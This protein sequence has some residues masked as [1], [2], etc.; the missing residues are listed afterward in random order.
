MSRNQLSASPVNC[1]SCS[2]KLNKCIVTSGSLIMN[3]HQL[4]RQDERPLQIPQL[5]PLVDHA[6]TKEIILNTVFLPKETVK[7]ILL[8]NL[9]ILIQ[10]RFS[11]TSRCDH[12]PEHPHNSHITYSD[13]MA[14]MNTSGQ[15]LGTVMSKITL[16]HL[17][18]MILM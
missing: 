1:S 14:E 16:G 3:F 13:S 11:I 6:A 5:N 17:K 4:L 10:E 8:A 12:I 18:I 7:E 9:C 15:N 2:C